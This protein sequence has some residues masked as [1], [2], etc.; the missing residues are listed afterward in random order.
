[1]CESGQQAE[2]DDKP[3]VQENHGT[4]STGSMT[5]ERWRHSAP[6]SS[7]YLHLALVIR[8]SSLNKHI[9]SYSLLMV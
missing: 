3:L 6:F 4:H 5:R 7:P 2:N 9:H 8:T 1:M